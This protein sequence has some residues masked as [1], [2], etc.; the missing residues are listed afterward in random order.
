M[1][2]QSL[3]E[4]V[5]LTK[6][7]NELKKLVQN[8]RTQ[9]VRYK[10]QVKR[11]IKKRKAERELKQR[12]KVFEQL[13]TEANINYYTGISKVQLFCKLHDYVVSFVQ[14]RWQGATM[15]LCIGA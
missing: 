14:R 15:A 1:Y 13:I 12:P 3:V 10:N 9:N 8:L 7:N 11:L 5:K 2:S 6:E 4:I